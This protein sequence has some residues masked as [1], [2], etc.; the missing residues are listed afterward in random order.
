MQVIEAV[1]LPSINVYQKHD[2]CEP[3]SQRGQ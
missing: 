3:A 2:V 1:Q